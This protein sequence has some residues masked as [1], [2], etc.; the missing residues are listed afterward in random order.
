MVVRKLRQNEEKYYSTPVDEVN[1]YRCV[2]AARPSFSNSFAMNWA[3][4]YRLLV[5][6]QEMTTKG[7]TSLL[8][9]K[10]RVS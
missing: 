5:R 1:V 8:T 9:G 7:N 10:I 6:W 2:A 3:L 4:L